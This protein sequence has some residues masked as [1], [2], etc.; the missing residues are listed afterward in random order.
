[1]DKDRL[2]GVMRSQQRNITGFQDW[3]RGA[4]VT[5]VDVRINPSTMVANY[6]FRS[7]SGALP[8][9]E[10]ERVLQTVHDAGYETFEVREISPV[11]A[12]REIIR[13]SL[14]S[15]PLVRDIA[16]GPGAGLIIK[17]QGP[18]EL[19]SEGHPIRVDPRIIN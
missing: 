18:I 9:E 7:D 2:S 19:V 1:M 12:V 5:C 13:F 15:D 10:R 4:G 14:S 11:E 3:M 17:N 6:E 8:L 16:T